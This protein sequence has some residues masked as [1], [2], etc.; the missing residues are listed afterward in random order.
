MTGEATHRHDGQTR[1]RASAVDNE[2]RVFRV[3]MLTG[4]FM[5]AEIAGGVVSGSLA[6]LADAGHMLT[7]TAALALA[8]VAFRIA[9][10]PADRK[11]SYG[12]H[13]FQVL[14]AFT[15]GLALIV[16]SCGIV[17]EAIRRLVH[18]VDVAAETMLAI[19]VAGLIV[20]LIGFAILHKGD[21]RNLNV[22]GAVLHVLSDL[23]GSA[24]AIAAGGVI[25]FTGWMPA[26]PL[27]SL[28][29]TV[30]ILRNAWSVI[31][32]SAHILL[33][34]TPDDVDVDELRATL[35]AAVPAVEDVHHVH[36]WSLTNER[37][38]ITL[39][40]GVSESGNHQETLKTIKRILRDRF[41]VD[42]ATIQ[43]EWTP[44]LDSRHSA[45]SSHPETVR[46]NRQTAR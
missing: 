17:I 18:P 10:R 23:L 9:R 24:A 34:G 42:H 2:R 21:R 11:R 22:R 45:E 14:A 33:E 46:R 26:D 43:I 28:L 40:V 27:L 41:G 16:I 15:N 35:R 29:I 31:T 36:A 7:D 25:L 1:G 19:A 20:N 3:M 8:W 32:T 5:L 13:R 12:Y 39:H 37:R 30:L 44:C 38:V 4:G 6:L